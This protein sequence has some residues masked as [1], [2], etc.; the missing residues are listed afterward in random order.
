MVVT[1]VNVFGSWLGD[2][3]AP[4]QQKQNHNPASGNNDN[5]GA[6]NNSSNNTNNNNNGGSSLVSGATG[7]NAGNTASTTTVTNSGNNNFFGTGNVKGTSTGGGTNSDATV[8]KSV[9]QDGSA[10]VAH[11]TI[12]VNL[13]W[14]LLMLPLAVMG[15]LVKKSFVPVKTLAIRGIHLFL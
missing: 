12:T 7:N 5:N 11:K 1:V 14:I 8:A 3:V 2:F 6:S 4:G 15:M 13:A 9:G 10:A